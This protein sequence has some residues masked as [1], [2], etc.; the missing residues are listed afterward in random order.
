MQASTVRFPRCGRP[1]ESGQY[2]DCRPMSIVPRLAINWPGRHV[3]DDATSQPQD[4]GKLLPA[5]RPGGSLI[6]PQVQAVV[7]GD[8]SRCGGWA[9]AARR[10][11]PCD[12]VIV[13]DGGRRD[14]A[15]PL[16]AVLAR[17]ASQWGSSTHSPGGLRARSEA[18]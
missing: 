17:S 2:Y 10:L 9:G 15:T 6:R 4:P 5:E 18:E 11:Q 3:G 14:P 12:L 13:R 7:L 8:C 1:L 16:T